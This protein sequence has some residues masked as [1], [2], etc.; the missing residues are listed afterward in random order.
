MKKKN[1]EIWHQSLLDRMERKI[2]M[3][4]RTKPNDPSRIKKGKRV[5]NHHACANK[6]AWRRSASWCKTWPSVPLL[7]YYTCGWWNSKSSSERSSEEEGTWERTLSGKN[8]SGEG[9][10]KKSSSL[11]KFVSQ[12]GFDKGKYIYCWMLIQLHDQASLSD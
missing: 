4:F 7:G 1:Q 5:K 10:L 6:Q 11:K 8:S 3:S 12:A 9:T 2:Y